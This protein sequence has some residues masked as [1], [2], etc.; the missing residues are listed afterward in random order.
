LTVPVGLKQAQIQ[1]Y[2]NGAA[3]PSMSAL[4]R[5]ALTLGVTIDEFVF[6]EGERGPDDDLRLQFDVPSESR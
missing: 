3:E 4:K 5:I 2:E 1:R 6:E